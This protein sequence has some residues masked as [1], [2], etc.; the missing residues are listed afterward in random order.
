MGVDAAAVL[1]LAEARGDADMAAQV[2]SIRDGVTH[3]QHEV[4]AILGRLRSGS[5]TEFGLPQAI[6][7][8]TAFWQSR[9][10]EVAITVKTVGADAGFGEAFDGVVYRIVQESLSNAMRHGKPRRI[11][12]AVDAGAD[13]EVTVEVT[14][15]GGG[16]KAT[17]GQRGF[18][19]RGMVE[20][21]TALGGDLDVRPVT[22][23]AGVHVIAHLPFPDN[24]RSNDGQ[25]MA[26]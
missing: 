26:A 25:G 16:M 5:L 6:Q 2:R 3:I 19:L 11:E 14:D 15:D 13:Q 1:K 12:I 7:N 23:P 17:N 18:G 8:L 10:P 22:E 20:R 24:G 21:V 9:R 4:K